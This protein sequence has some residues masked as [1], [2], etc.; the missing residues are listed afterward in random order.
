M[1]LGDMFLSIEGQKTGKILGESKD[2]EYPGQIQI[3]GWTWGMTSSASMGSSAGSTKTALSEIN[4]SKNVDTA[5]TALMSV[6]R[7]NE[8]IKR[9]VITVRKAGTNPID[10]F[11]ITFER[12][13][14]TSH[15]IGSQA[16]PELMEQLSIAFEK[17]EVQYSAQDATGGKKGTSTFAADVTNN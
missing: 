17:I 5:S 4:I 16:G 8:L 12:A 1:A 11:K 14:I 13:R 2:A 3:L 15:T 9:G 7:S 6:M 10:Y